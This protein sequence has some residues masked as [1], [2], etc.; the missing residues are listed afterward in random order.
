MRVC[1]FLL[2]PSLSPFLFS[3]LFLSYRSLSNY[4]IRGDR[5]WKAFRILMLL[6]GRVMSFMFLC[7][8][9]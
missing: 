3:L 4:S 1:F 9:F 8:I 5:F 7:E 2:R 6:Q